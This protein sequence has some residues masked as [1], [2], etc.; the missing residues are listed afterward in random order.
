MHRNAYIQL[1]GVVL[2]WAVNI[3]LVKVALSDAPPMALTCLRFA[4]GVVLFGAIAWTLGIP[5]VPRPNER[6][7]LAAIGIVQFGLVSA[8]SAAG[9]PSASGTTA[10][11]A[12]SDGLV[13]SVT[14]GATRA[15]IR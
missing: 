11:L 2:L 4:G 14:A 5:L 9:R 8:F 12:S 7:A 1:S 6:L 3:V 10:K 13:S 15:A